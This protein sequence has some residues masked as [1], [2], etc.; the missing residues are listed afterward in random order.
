M[1]NRE[2]KRN[3]NVQKLR[4]CRKQLSR[5]KNKPTYESGANLSFV[6]CFYLK[7]AE[8]GKLYFF[9]ACIRGV[10]VYRVVENIADEKIDHRIW[11]KI[12]PYFNK[13][14]HT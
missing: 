2:L 9:G 13:I 5:G 8:C 10:P 4:Y 3:G 11:G 7:C 14:A 12:G 6:V 1:E